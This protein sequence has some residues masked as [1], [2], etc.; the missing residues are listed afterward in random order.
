MD[1]VNLEI[2]IKSLR[3]KPMNEPAPNSVEIESDSSK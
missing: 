2:G 3:C 1:G